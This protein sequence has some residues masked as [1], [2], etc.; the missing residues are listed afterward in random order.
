M[1]ATRPC[2]LTDTGSRTSAR[3]TSANPVTMP[4]SKVLRGSLWL[5]CRLAIAQAAWGCSS[6]GDDSSDKTTTLATGGQP[7]TTASLTGPSSD[8]AS[9]A[10]PTADSTQDSAASTQGS[11]AT[12]TSSGSGDTNTGGSAG[13]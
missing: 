6:T 3:R 4:V 1:K 11:V 13:A 2:F 7:G 5:T 9:T 8:S 12:S 10:E